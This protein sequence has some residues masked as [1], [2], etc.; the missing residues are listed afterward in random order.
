MMRL[1]IQHVTGFEYDGK[2]AASYNQARLTPLSTPFQ[3]LVHHRVEIS[4]KPWV[5]DYLDYFGTRVTA[6]EVAEPHA[7][8]TVTAHS[9]VQ[10]SRPAA[11]W[12]QLE[13]DDLETR[14]VA[15]RWT[16]YL[17]LPELVA[18]PEDLA[19]EVKTIATTS[20][21][22]GTAARSI[23]E[24]VHSAVEYAPGATDVESSA[25][26]VWDQ[27]AGISQDM[28]HLAI[29][30]L[31]SVGIPARYVSGYSHPSATPEIGESLRG[32]SH[33]WLEYWD[34]DWKPFD[35]TN[36]SEPGDSYVSVA[37]G[38]DYTD[39]RPLAGIYSGAKTSKMTAY[40]DITRLA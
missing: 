21:N 23:C 13:W 5:Y 38:R 15:D 20:E 24:L 11:A 3:I 10:V 1:R 40:V 31:R 25:L 8:L 14:E 7:S 30:G 18:P 39:V 27:K 16:E 17:V 36:A 12:P 34:G 22:P 33:A 9:T 32:N 2:A 35:P 26:E 4:P 6:F 29:G 28:V 19:A 37:K